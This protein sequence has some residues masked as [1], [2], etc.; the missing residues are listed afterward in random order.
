MSETRVRRPVPA[1]LRASHLRRSRESWF[2]GRSTVVTADLEKQA[3]KMV[4][5]HEDG[6]VRCKCNLEASL[7]TVSK[8]GPN[9]GRHFWHVESVYK[10][11]QS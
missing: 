2:V 1:G 11:V 8:D 6:V 7:S 4:N 3:A 10:G 5:T 9:K